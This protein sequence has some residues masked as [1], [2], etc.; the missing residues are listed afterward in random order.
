MLNLLLEWNA[1]PF[2]ANHAGNNALTIAK[3]G[4]HQ[5]VYI[6]VLTVFNMMYCLCV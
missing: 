2:L 6:Y 1:D 5:E 4:D 3:S